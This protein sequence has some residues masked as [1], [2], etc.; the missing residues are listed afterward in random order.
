[1]LSGNVFEP[2]ALDE[3]LPSWRGDP[4]VPVSVPVVKDYFYGLTQRHAV[5]LPTP[6]QMKVRALMLLAGS[7]PSASPL[8]PCRCSSRAPAWSITQLDRLK[9]LYKY[10]Q[11]ADGCPPLSVRARS[12]PAFAFHIHLLTFFFRCSALGP[13]SLKRIASGSRLPSILSTSHCATSW[14][15]SQHACRRLLLITVTLLCRHVALDITSWWRRLR[16]QYVRDDDR[17][18][19]T[20]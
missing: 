10:S 17:T 7:P 11:T 15:N 1:M 8:S 4:A 12:E 16:C 14:C 18:T 2:R 5:W 13:E 6:P 19:A 20:T 9:Y 3:L